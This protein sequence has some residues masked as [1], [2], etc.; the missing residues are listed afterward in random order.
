MWFYV[1]FDIELVAVMIA[2]FDNE[3]VGSNPLPPVKSPLEID[4]KQLVILVSR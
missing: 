3:E 1:S 4:W 2:L